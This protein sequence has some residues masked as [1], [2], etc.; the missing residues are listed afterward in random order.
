MQG[1][2]PRTVYTKPPPRRLHAADAKPRLGP[3]TLR[4]AKSRT[5]RSGTGL[6]LALLL[7]AA[8]GLPLAAAQ[9]TTSGE[10]GVHS[11]RDMK[12]AR[13]YQRSWSSCS[14]RVSKRSASSHHGLPRPAPCISDMS[15]L[16]SG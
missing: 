9:V 16:M 3:H 15:E 13:A 6:L 12:S 1:L 4:R 10:G 8:G 7:C 11:V 5:R 14:G 2:G